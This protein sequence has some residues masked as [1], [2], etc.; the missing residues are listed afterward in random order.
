[1]PVSLRHILI[2]VAGA[3]SRRPSHTSYRSPVQRAEPD[4][5]KDLTP[6]RKSLDIIVIRAVHDILRRI[7]VRHPGDDKGGTVI[8]GDVRIGFVQ[9]QSLLSHTTN[10]AYQI[11]MV[12]LKRL[13]SLHV[14][15]PSAGGWYRPRPPRP[16]LAGQ[17][18]HRKQKRGEQCLSFHKYS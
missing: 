1:M 9:S 13:E 17:R 6:L 14:F 16:R 10:R 5:P 18:G 4:F 2:R 8:R 12:I 7:T 15:L 3:A 11:D